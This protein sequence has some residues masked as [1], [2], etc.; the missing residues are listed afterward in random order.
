MPEQHG[1]TDR[2]MTALKGNRKRLKWDFCRRRNNSQ[3]DEIGRKCLATRRSMI[4][5]VLSLEH[6]RRNAKHPVEPYAPVIS[7]LAC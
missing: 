6:D 2:K 3:T 7:S 1:K 5:G 4:I